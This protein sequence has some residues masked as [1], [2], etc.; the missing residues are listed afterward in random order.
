VP[1]GTPQYALSL[2]ADYSVQAALPPRPDSGTRGAPVACAV[3]L[4]LALSGPR[5]RNGVGSNAST[6]QRQETLGFIEGVM[7]RELQDHWATVLRQVVPDAD[8]KI[9]PWPGR[10]GLFLITR[11]PMVRDPSDTRK[12]EFKVYFH[13]MSLN[14]T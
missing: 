3:H 9:L 8:I 13:A 5:Y 1:V 12:L 2:V 11:T 6:S 4:T 10:G 14:A 7:D